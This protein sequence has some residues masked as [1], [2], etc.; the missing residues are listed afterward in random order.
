MMIILEVFCFFFFVFFYNV[1]IV[2]MIYL[3]KNY[4]IVVLYVFNKKLIKKESKKMF[5][6]LFRLIGRKNKIFF[7]KFF[8]I[9]VRKE[10]SCL[11]MLKIVVNVF[12]LIFGKI[13][14]E[15]INIFFINCNI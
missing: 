14:F 15:L 9:W 5:V 11:Y 1:G 3:I 12:L 13:N 4:N 10:I 6:I 2:L 8:V 7:L